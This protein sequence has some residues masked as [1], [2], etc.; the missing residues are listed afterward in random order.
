[1]EKEPLEALQT[2]LV[3]AVSRCDVQVLRFT[4]FI[5]GV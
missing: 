2:A 5:Q 3:L 4:A 1:V